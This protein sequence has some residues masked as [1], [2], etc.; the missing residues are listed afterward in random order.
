MSPR[1][2]H[3]TAAGGHAEA[4]ATGHL[5]ESLVRAMLPHCP[6]LFWPYI[7]L[8]QD[9]R[10]S[11]CFGEEDMCP[12]RVVNLIRGAL[13]CHPTKGAWRCPELLGGWAADLT[14]QSPGCCHAAGAQQQG[15]GT[16]DPGVFKAGC[17]VSLQP[18]PKR[19][20]DLCICLEAWV[21]E[22]WASNSTAQL[23][24]CILTLSGRVTLGCGH[25]GPASHLLPGP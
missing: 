13:N 1:P 19:C 16:P 24:E 17:S 22:R 2:G 11:T 3:P 9:L 14:P 18:P 21:E 7:S 6:L 12:Q 8:F 10:G 15:K 20:R 5:W 4:A 23:C 25:P